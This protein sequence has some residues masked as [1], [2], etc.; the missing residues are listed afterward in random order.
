MLQDRRD[1]LKT[2]AQVGGLTAA[3]TLLGSQSVRASEEEGAW[4]AVGKV[5]E[6]PTGDP[7]PIRE[8]RAWPA[9][10]PLRSPEISIVKTDEQTVSAISTRCTHRA[11]TVVWKKDEFVC[12]CHAAT[13]ELDGKVK[14][15]PAK[16]PLPSLDVR[17]EDG[18]ILVRPLG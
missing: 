14:R 15:G 8:A 16:L 12:P 7:T 9:G 18:V 3:A 10:N 2:V 5:E 17:V 6:Y 13:F 1:F 4:I 11:C